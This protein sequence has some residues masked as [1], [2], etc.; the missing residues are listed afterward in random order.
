[1]LPLSVEGGDA[2]DAAATVAEDGI[3]LTIVHRETQKEAVVALPGLR[4]LSGTLLFCEDILHDGFTPRSLKER[5]LPIENGAI[6]LPPA[7]FA[8]VHLEVVR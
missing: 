5:P 2:I 1:M 3:F 6:R 8:A 4:A 7:S